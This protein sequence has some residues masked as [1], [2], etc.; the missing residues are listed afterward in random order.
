MQQ[1][2][3]KYANRKGPAFINSTAPPPDIQA[4]MSAALGLVGKQTTR[5]HFNRKEAAQQRRITRMRRV[6]QATGDVLQ[7]WHQKNR[8][9]YRVAL[10]TVTYR[11]DAEWEPD[12]ITK[13]MHHYRSWLHR[14]DVKARGLWVLELQKRGAPHYHILLWIPKGLTPPKPDKQGWWPHGMSN[15]KWA[16][17][18]VGYAMKYASKVNSKDTPMPKGARLYGVFGVPVQ[19]GYYRAP[20]WLRALSAPGHHVTRHASGWWV[21]F[22]RG[23]AWRSPWT[24]DYIEGE[25]VSISWVGWS[26]NDVI[27]LY[28]LKTMLEVEGW[29]LSRAFG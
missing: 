28:T 14:R 19:L 18:P 25:E 15:C 13:L 10:I 16:R 24:L 21:D 27:D 8:H 3:K 7:K 29:K 2:S 17:K 26:D 22:T 9:R 6:V 20:E 1:N 4:K 23:W 5:T 12:H 11:P